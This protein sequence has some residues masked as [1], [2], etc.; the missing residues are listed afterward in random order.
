MSKKYKLE[1]YFRSVKVDVAKTWI[2]HQWKPLMCSNIIWFATNQQGSDGNADLQSAC[3]RYL[4][5]LLQQV[6]IINYS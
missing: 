2:S 1:E 4:L 6:F 5:I 3:A